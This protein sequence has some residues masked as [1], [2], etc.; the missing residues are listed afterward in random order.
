MVVTWYVYLNNTV[1]VCEGCHYWLIEFSCCCKST[2]VGWRWQCY[3]NMAVYSSRPTTSFVCSASCFLCMC[4]L[5][6][7]KLIQIPKS[8]FHS[9]F[10]YISESQPPTYPPLPF[11]MMW[12][13]PLFF[14][15][16]LF[17]PFFFL[18]FNAAFLPSSLSCQILVKFH[19]YATAISF[20]VS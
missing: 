7:L 15:C 10:P 5:P 6:P 1:V 16:L 18:L 4:K 17:L 20:R 12:H 9:L 14:V 3:M 11:L 8:L 13:F 19:H 2:C